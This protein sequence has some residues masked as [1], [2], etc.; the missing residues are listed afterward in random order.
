[1]VQFIDERWG[2]ETLREALLAMTEVDLLDVL[3]VS[4]A[5]FLGEWQDW[6]D[7]NPH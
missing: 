3:G 6:V 5:A 1:M 4:E 7:R 2:R